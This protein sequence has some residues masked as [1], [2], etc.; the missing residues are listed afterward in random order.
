MKKLLFISFLF[1]SVS[2]FGQNSNSVIQVADIEIIPIDLISWTDLEN[3]F[4][5][6]DAICHC[7]YRLDSNFTYRLYS[8]DCVSSIE[9]D[10]GTWK[11]QNNNA[12]VLKSNEEVKVFQIVKVSDTRFFIPPNKLQV[13]KRDLNTTLIKYP[14][15]TKS[16][17]F[18]R[19]LMLI[20]GGKYFCGMI[21]PTGT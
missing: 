15:M 4:S 18:S 3:G 13:F 7:G 11:I 9:I 8:N 10:D 14:S 21:R 20:L 6:N 1:I 19:G 17:S 2:I 12:L 16:K 5:R